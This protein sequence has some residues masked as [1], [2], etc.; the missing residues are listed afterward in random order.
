MYIYK[1]DQQGRCLIKWPVSELILVSVPHPFIIVL[2]ING[3]VAVYTTQESLR[4]FFT[5]YIFKK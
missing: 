2:L 3:P 5:Y 4:K 1:V